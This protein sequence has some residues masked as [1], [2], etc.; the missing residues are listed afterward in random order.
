MKR[1][2]AITMVR[3]DDFYLKKWTAWYGSQIGEENLYIFLDGTDQP[4]PDWCPAAHITPVEKIPGQVVQAE[5]RRLKLLSDEAAR[6][7]REGYDLVIGTDADEILVV[8]P[9]RGE[10]LAEYLDKADIKTSLSGLGVDVGQHLDEESDIREDEPF[11]SQR[12]YAHLCTRYT[13]PS[14]LAGPYQW[15]SGFHR[16][17]CHN[18]HIGKDLFLFHIGY[19]DMG[20]I[21]ARFADKDRA[22][23]GWTQHLKKRSRTIRYC[24]ALPKHD[25]DKT[26]GWVRTM[27]SICRP[28]Y[29]WN[30]PG[31]LE[32]RIV[33]R[34]PERFQKLI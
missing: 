7:F 4:I 16:V 1:I 30:K 24:T 11:L 2:A 31:M 23:A 3:K 14:V 9:A 12:H 28:P 10:N 22:A 20:R 5:K 6:L 19:F 17:K 8:D 33:V 18:F 27:Q 26:V 15:G 34:I 29:A 21:Q 13:K 25:W 32:L